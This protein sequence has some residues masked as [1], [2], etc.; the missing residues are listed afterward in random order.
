MQLWSFNSVEGASQGTGS[1]CALLRPRD[2]ETTIATRTLPKRALPA[3]SSHLRGAR[4]SSA[5]VQDSA[6]RLP[7][8]NFQH[9]PSGKEN[10]K[11]FGSYFP[12]PPPP[13]SPPQPTISKSQGRLG[14]DRAPEPGTEGA[15]Q[16]RIVPRKAAAVHYALWQ[17]TRLAQ[18][19][20]G[21]PRA[22]RL[23]KEL[24]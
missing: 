5:D 7:R 1:L 15:H 23:Q 12:P 16:G 22:E 18:H 11:L 4:S 20:S 19:G 17:S 21:T 8:R 3:A 14:K 13:P 6:L 2:A 10:T 9:K 24:F